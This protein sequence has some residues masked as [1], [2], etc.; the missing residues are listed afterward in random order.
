PLTQEP[1]FDIIEGN[2]FSRMSGEVDIHFKGGHNHA[3]MKA[4][5]ASKNPLLEPNVDFDF[6]DLMNDP[7][8]LASYDI[9]FLN[10]GLSESLEDLDSVLMDYV[11]NGGIL[12]ATDWAAGYLNSVTD[13]GTNY[14]T[15]YDPEKSGTSLTT[16]ATLLD[17]TLAD[18]LALNFGIVLDDTIEI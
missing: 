17:T 4:N 5:M 6:Q 11:A 3:T 15:F 1:L 12:Y 16:T 10:C 14:M 7:V 18:W 2:Y 13:G 9:V 8:L